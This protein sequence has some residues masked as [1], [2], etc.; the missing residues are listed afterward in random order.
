MARD[1]AQ[2]R[3]SRETRAQTPRLGRDACQKERATSRH[4]DRDFKVEGET[5]DEDEFQS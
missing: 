3:L 1:Q 4:K 2:E 5:D